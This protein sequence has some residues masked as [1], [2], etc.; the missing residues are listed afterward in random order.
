MLCLLQKSRTDV[1]HLPMSDNIIQVKGLCKHYRALA[2]S[3][4]NE[5][6]QQ[7]SRWDMD[8]DWEK[9][10]KELRKAVCPLF[11]FNA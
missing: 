9:G 10:R 11:L 2:L 3:V 1:T 5:L 7:G 8:G 6:I 4:A